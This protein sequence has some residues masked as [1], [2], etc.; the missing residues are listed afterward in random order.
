[1]PSKIKHV[2][3]MR[4]PPRLVPYH[5][6]FPDLMHESALIVH[7][8]RFGM[9][10]VGEEQQQALRSAYAQTYFLNDYD[11]NGEVERIVIDLAKRSPLSSLV[12]QSEFDILRAAR[13]RE[14]LGIEGL[15]GE[16]AALFRDKLA[17]KHA[18]RALGLPVPQCKAVHSYTDVVEFVTNHGFPVVV[19]PRLGAGSM[20]VHVIRDAE[21][22]AAFA[23]T[24]LWSS[25]DDV[26]N[27]MV[28]AFVH[29]DMLHV[30]GLVANGR[31]EVVVPSRYINGCLAFQ[32]GAFLG[33]AAL[34]PESNASRKAHA[35]LNSLVEGL[36][37]PSAASFHLELF[38]REDGSLCLCEVAIRTGGAKV[39]QAVKFMTGVDLDHY[40]A[41]L[42]CGQPAPTLAPVT[43]ELAGW[44]LLPPRAGRLVRVPDGDLKREGVVEFDLAALRL[45]HDFQPA[46][47]SIDTVCSFVVRANS[48]EA[49]RD[50]ILQVTAE[51]V[52]DLQWEPLPSESA[53]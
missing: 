4:V 43:G 50:R 23:K 25:L 31:A 14:H 20:G 17:M 52:A 36:P 24:R 47:T 39:K 35:F 2:F 32:E 44:G 8:G 53:A 10:G 49:V 48:S 46:R 3:L 45:P 41:A 16:A 15:K 13:L 42:Q 1:M 9:W 37:F 6:W 26:A 51:V 27:L 30:D 19:K 22:L 21:Q 33:S 40:A 11:S 29:G 28:E 38:E 12:V 7:S 18:V 5:E 34:D